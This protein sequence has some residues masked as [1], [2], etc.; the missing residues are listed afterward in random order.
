M[1]GFNKAKALK[2]KIDE[3]ERGHLVA[4]FTQPIEQ[5]PDLL[6]RVEVYSRSNGRNILI[7]A[8]DNLRTQKFLQ[9][10][11]YEK[12]SFIYL[13]IGFVKSRFSVSTSKVPE[14]I[15]VE[16]GQGRDY[17]GQPVWLPTALIASGIACY[18]VH[19]L[20]RDRREIDINSV[21]IHD[22]VKSLIT[23]STCDYES[24]ITTMAS[25]IQHGWRLKY[26][27]E[28]LCEFTQYL[29]SIGV[30]LS[31][32]DVIRALTLSAS[33]HTETYIAFGENE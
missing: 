24:D 25:A 32:E 7:D 1:V 22:V 21:N 4:A 19:N 13:R 23:P 14:L 8:T 28:E 31:F 6:N 33:R 27:F 29:V 9:D 16:L 5:I 12:E 15:N 17:G 10:F 30:N 3:L 11:V 18:I 26:S 2:L 20:N